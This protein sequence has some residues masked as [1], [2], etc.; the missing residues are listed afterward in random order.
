MELYNLCK[1]KDVAQDTT[2]P[3][4]EENHKF[5]YLVRKDCEYSHEK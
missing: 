2:E 3:K 5:L 4:V 1:L